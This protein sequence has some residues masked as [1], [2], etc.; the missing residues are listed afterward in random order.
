MPINPPP[1][2]YS[3]LTTAQYLD[4]FQ[5]SGAFIRDVYPVNPNTLD[6]ISIDPFTGDSN[7]TII[8]PDRSTWG[9][10]SDSVTVSKN[11]KENGAKFGVGM[12]SSDYFAYHQSPSQTIVGISFPKSQIRGVLTTGGYEYAPAHEIGHL[13]GLWGP[14]SIHHEEYLDPFITSINSKGRPASGPR[15]GCRSVRRP[16]AHPGSPRRSGCPWS[17]P[18]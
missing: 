9:L 5:K 4:T 2:T 16:R 14:S 18:S 13:F 15:L 7:N 1:N 3:S 8:A 17:G 10:M 6:I 12:V 11:A